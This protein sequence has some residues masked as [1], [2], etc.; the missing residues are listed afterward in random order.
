MTSPRSKEDWK[1]R[2]APHLSTSLRTASDQITRTS[3]VQEWLHNA[4][5]EA[6]EGLRNVSGMQG[7]MQGY[8]RMMDALEDRFPELLEAVDELTEGCGQVD[9]HWRPM[10]PNY[11]RL[12][13]DFDRSFTVAV[14]EQLDELTPEAARAA[15]QMV[16]DA[17]PEGSPFPNRPN[18]V[19]GLVAFDGTC[20]G[21][22]VN[23]Y[24]GEDRQRRYRDASLLPNSRN[25]IDNLSLDDA[26]MRLVQLLAPADDPSPSA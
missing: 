25:D 12:Y 21:V 16:A 15:V 5:M 13:I 1:A 7:E 2:I 14:F 10:N 23:E 22:Q 20:V 26:G 6:A 4:S 19:T 11:S 3:A 24:L 17:L 8:M 18:T 9:L